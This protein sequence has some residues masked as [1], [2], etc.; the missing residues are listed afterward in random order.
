MCSARSHPERIYISHK[1]LW[2]WGLALLYAISGVTSLA[3]EVLWARMLSMQFGVSIFGVV[4]T[5]AAFMAGLGLGSLIGTRWAARTSKP[6]LFFAALEISVALYALLLPALLQGAGGWVEV[7]AAQLTLS[8]WYALQGAVAL[9]L[10]A[11][12]ACAMGAGFALVLKAIQ[13]TPVSLGMIY[14]LNALGAVCGAL[15]PLWSL[16]LL[17]WIVSIRIVAA[18]G[19]AVGVGGVLLAR[20]GHLVVQ[21]ARSST[22]SEIR[23]PLNVL[24]A[25]AGIGMASLML[26]VGW[27]R[28]YGMVMLRT[29]YVLAVILAVYLLGIALGSLFLP[30]FAKPWLFAALPLAGGV[31]TL[32]SLW[33]LPGVSAWIEHGQFASFAGALWA[34]ALALSLFTLPVT[35]ALG[36]WLPMLNQRF[37]NGGMGGAWLYGANSMG[38]AVGAMLAGFVGIPLLGTSATVAVAG[39]LLAGFGL[40]WAKSRTVWLALPVLALLALPLWHLP[41]VRE[42]LPQGQAHSRD[43]SLY[44]DA[45]S[46][47]HVVQQA[48]GQRLLM[49]DLQ[50]M[51]ASTEPSAVQIQANQGRLP[52]LLHPSPQSVLFLGLG[53]GIS[54]GG[55]L[56]FPGLERTAVELSQG[57]INAAGTW[58]APANGNVMRQLSVQRDDAKHFLSATR[59]T[60]DVIIGD[61]FHPDLAGLSSLLSVQQ[62]QR[63]RERLSDDGIFVQWLALNQFDAESFAAVLR[64][65]HRV[66]PDAQLFMDGMHI[67]LVGPKQRFGGAAALTKNLKRLSEVEQAA[68][69]GN[70]GGWTWLGRY[71]GPIPDSVGPI[72]DEWA[73]YIEFRLPRARYAGDVSLDGLLARLLRQRPDIDAAMKLL[74]VLPT[75]REVFERAYVATDL[76]A[77]AWV[78]AIQGGGAEASRLTRMAYQANPRDRWIANALADTMLELLPQIRQRGLS[79][80][81]ALQRIQRVS[82]DH[83]ETVRALWHLEHAAG[84]IQAATQ[85]RLK[86]QGISPFDREVAEQTLGSKLGENR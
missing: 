41:Q 15:L 60:Y 86:L 5:V 80:R 1:L 55:S 64:T 66:F 78:A 8:Q 84:N 32:L 28:L 39:L 2:G 49:T 69:T 42:L 10:L 61:L 44:E 27:T 26:E 74:G 46:L 25:Y 50:R 37:G 71:W 68:V 19:F 51:D 7:L 77:R 22:E 75:D 57:A 9:F 16:P 56:P 82:P 59:Q 18:A 21:P 36:A 65:F 6:L 83:V 48:D 34:Q 35:L 45:V 33:A 31:F 79:E 29:E 23:P 43:L 63:A 67:A 53:T 30:R 11:V 38:A 40:I 85:Y 20:F 13:P 3:Y 70:E 54:A 76:V 14:G 47:T 4:L 73:P 12:P 58:F 62:F 52:L 24:V 72:Q 81:E 17:G